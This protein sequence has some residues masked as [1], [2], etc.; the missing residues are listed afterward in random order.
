MCTP[1]TLQC[2]YA[3]IHRST[4]YGV[5]LMVKCSRS[6]TQHAKAKDQSLDTVLT[7]LECSGRTRLQLDR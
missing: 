5:D 7:Y 3:L 4:E 1:A 2:L 6:G